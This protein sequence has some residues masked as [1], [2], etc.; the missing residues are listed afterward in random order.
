MSNATYFFK[1]A[2]PSGA[3]NLPNLRRYQAL[4][5]KSESAALSSACGKVYSCA[6]AALHLRQ[7]WRLQD[8]GNPRLHAFFYHRISTD[9][10]ANLFVFERVFW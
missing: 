4:T 5:V 1:I 2:H 8:S 10:L 7:T 9:F 6:L 3:P